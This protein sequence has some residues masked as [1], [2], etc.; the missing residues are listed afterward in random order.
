MKK[1][2]ILVGLI[3]I[4]FFVISFLTNIIGPLVPDIIQS[5]GLSLTMAAFLPFAF[6]V[7]YG[8]MSIPSGILIEMYGE[9]KVMVFAFLISSL[10]AFLFA[11]NA[12][13]I[14]YL[15]SLF[16]IGTGMAMLQV[17]I[18]PLLRAIGGEKDFA[19]NSVLG[20]LFFGLASFLSPLVYSYVVINSSDSVQDSSWITQ[21]LQKI[22]IPNFEWI[23]LYWIFAII[24]LLMVLVLLMVKFPMVERK[25]DEKAGAL[26]THL[27]LLKQ[28]M[29]LLYFFAIFCYVGTEQGIA[30]WISQF[31]SVYH[32]IDPQIQGAKTIS[33]FWGMMTLGTLLGLVLLKFLDS[34][35]VLIVTSVASI[36]ALFIGLFGNSSQALIAFPAIGFFIATMWSIII[37]LALNSVAEAHGSFSGILVTGIVG[38]AVIPFIV[39]ALGDVYGLRIGMVFLFS[40][41]LFIL[42]IGFWS[43]PLITNE[44]FKYSSRKMKSN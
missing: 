8:V 20:Q 33:N 1:T 41:L 12:H 11:L 26:A 10:G 2:T 27:M 42:S 30:N 22:T 29:V 3:L 6:F 15:V 19:F 40:T 23:S 35:K 18:N 31:L 39:G 17:A 34:R 7:A 38:G 16:F 36:V 43:K 24:S 32:D 25:E 21:L 4:I 44:T 28:P 37:S 14:F 13:Y 9:K 5:F